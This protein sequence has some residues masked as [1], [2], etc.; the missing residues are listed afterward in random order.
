LIIVNCRQPEL[1]RNQL[2][3]RHA[4]WESLGQKGSIGSGK[5]ADPSAETA[6]HLQGFQAMI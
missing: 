3:K 1:D 5:T 2:A 4:S 6:N